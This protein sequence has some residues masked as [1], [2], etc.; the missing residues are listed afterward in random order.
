M[1]CMTKMFIPFLKHYG[2]SIQSDDTT[3]TSLLSTP[4]S[5]VSTDRMRTK[6]NGFN[7]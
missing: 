4:L 7:K 3:Q 2:Q 1:I 6:E 5:F